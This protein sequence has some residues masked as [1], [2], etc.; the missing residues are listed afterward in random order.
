LEGSPDGDEDLK[1][2]ETLLVGLDPPA[3]GDEGG[4]GD[5]VK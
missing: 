3:E 2:V 1:G 4:S 5:R